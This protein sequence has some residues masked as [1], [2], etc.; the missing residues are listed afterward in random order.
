MLR[1]LWLILILVGWGLVLVY[2]PRLPTISYWIAAAISMIG[3]LYGW[4]MAKR[5]RLIYFFTFSLSLGSAVSLKGA[6]AWEKWVE[7][8]AFPLPISANV[9]YKLLLLF[10]MIMAGFITFANYRVSLNF[11]Q[12]RGNIDKGKLV[13][14]H[15]EKNAL[16]SFIKWLKTR[17]EPMEVR[18]SLGTEIPFN[19]E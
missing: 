14:L 9:I 4:V 7:W 10:T 3:Y 6:S 18:I 11:I 2:M 17:K 15:R 5:N 19:N 8:S 13:K 16:Q 1:F 12:R